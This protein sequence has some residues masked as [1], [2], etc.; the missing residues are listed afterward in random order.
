MS[1]PSR[2]RRCAPRPPDHDVPREVREVDERWIQDYF[3]ENTAL[4]SEQPFERLQRLRDICRG[5]YDIALDLRLDEDTRFLLKHIDAATKCGVGS[6]ACHP[7]LD[8]ALPPAI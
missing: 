6:L 1:S 5:S 8:I 3:P 4:W 2:R 7:F